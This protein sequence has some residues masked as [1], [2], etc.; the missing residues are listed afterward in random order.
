MKSIMLGSALGV[1]GLAANTRGDDVP[2]APLKIYILAGQSNMTGM[3]GNHTLEH[4]L[5]L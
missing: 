1:C 4:I 2:G 5:K 3:V